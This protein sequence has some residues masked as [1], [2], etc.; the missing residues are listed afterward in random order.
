MKLLSL[1]AEEI[2]V[3]NILT[4]YA[5]DYIFFVSHDVMLTL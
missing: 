4:K 5:V 2:V 3:Q 1:A